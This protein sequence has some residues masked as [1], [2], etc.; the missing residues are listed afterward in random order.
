MGRWT[1]CAT[2]ALTTVGEIEAII[3]VGLAPRTAGQD[4]RIAGRAMAEVITVVPAQPT[5]GQAVV[6]I[7]VAATGGTM[8]V[9]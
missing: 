5:A 9:M 1:D 4:R 6:V 2:K 8:S 7:T 3:V